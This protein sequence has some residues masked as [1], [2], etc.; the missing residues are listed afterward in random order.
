MYSLELLRYGLKSDLG[1]DIYQLYFAIWWLNYGHSKSGANG[2]SGLDWRTKKY[3][4][5]PRFYD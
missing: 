5:L 2:I 4:V 1:R 3:V